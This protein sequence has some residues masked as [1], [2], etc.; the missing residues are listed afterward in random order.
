MAISGLPGRTHATGSGRFTRSLA[1]AALA[2]LAAGSSPSAA[3]AAKAT[4]PASVT[5]PLRSL[6]SYTIHGGYT[7]AG[8][9]MRNLGHGKIKITGVP[10][11]ARVKAAFLLWDILGGSTP[12]AAFA[13]G[14]LNATPVT[15]TLTAKGLGPCWAGTLDNY[16]Y[17]ANVTGQ[18]HR[19]GSYRLSGFASGLRTGVDP[20][21]QSTPPLIDGASLIVVYQRA[22]LPQKFI[23]IG[24]GATEA[25]AGQKLKATISGF[26]RTST[27]TAATTFIVGDPQKPYLDTA[28]VNGTR[29]P[30]IKFHGGAP[31]AGGGS[32]SRGNLW[33]N[34]TVNVHSLVPTGSH[35]ATVSLT[36]HVTAAGYDCIVWVGQVLTVS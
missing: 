23:Q 34:V 4:A 19:N 17:A 33:D 9:G 26:T 28:S 1:L 18:V 36:P 16:A 30:G 3:S 21:T 14:K 6:A 22:T 13:H 11:G 15:G 2:S 29:L 31:K 27:G 25:Q 24:A 5:G 12:A 7:A 20:W 10:A 8:I 32:Y 35:K